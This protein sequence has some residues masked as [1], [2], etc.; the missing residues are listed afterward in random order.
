MCKHAAKSYRHDQQGRLQRTALSHQESP[1]GLWR[2]RQLRGP[3]LRLT[4]AAPLPDQRGGR[5]PGSASAARSAPSPEAGLQ[6]NQEPAHIF[7]P[8]HI[9][10]RSFSAQGTHTLPWSGRRSQRMLSRCAS[11]CSRCRAGC[12]RSQDVLAA[13]QRPGAWRNCGR[14]ERHSTAALSQ[15]VLTFS[16]L[17]T[18]KSG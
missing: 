18:L 5:L 7:T 16:C 6:A 11:A 3:P 17:M 15:S 13:H 9:F 8:A 1:P 12:I 4:L 2:L 10:I 14:H